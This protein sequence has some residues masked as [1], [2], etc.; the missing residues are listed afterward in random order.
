MSRTSVLHILLT[1]MFSH[2]RQ[3]LKKYVLVNNQL[4]NV[5]DA[6]FTSLFNRALAKG[7][8]DGVF[9]RPKG[10]PSQRSIQCMADQ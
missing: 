5:K 3:A 9:A 7:S 2:S 4:G 8:D 6:Q 10:K 1:Y